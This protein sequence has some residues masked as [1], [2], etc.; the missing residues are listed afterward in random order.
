M[1]NFG[2]KK[3][4]PYTVCS[5]CPNRLP[6]KQPLNPVTKEIDDLCQT[7]RSA[8]NRAN[9]YFE[10]D[11]AQLHTQVWRKQLGGT[12]PWE[13]AEKDYNGEW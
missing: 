5:I 6:E 7:C 4:N 9:Y 2:N 13:D 8:I 11:I 1:A 12:D 3:P 10:D